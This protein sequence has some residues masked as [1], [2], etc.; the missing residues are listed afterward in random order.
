[1]LISR[2]SGVGNGLIFLGRENGGLNRK[3]E[4]SA[5]WM[6]SFRAIQSAAISS[7]CDVSDRRSCVICFPPPSASFPSLS[8]PLPSPPASIPRSCFRGTRLPQTTNGGAAITE[9]LQSD[10]RATPEQLEEEGDT[11]TTTTTTTT[12]AA[13]RQSMNNEGGKEEEAVRDVTAP[14]I[15]P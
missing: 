11:T 7:P 14:P 3:I 15:D 8:L 9:Q 1:M 5:K 10:S 6:A 12:P 2:F 4:R 13:F